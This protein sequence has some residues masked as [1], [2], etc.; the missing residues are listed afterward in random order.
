MKT[1][2]RNGLPKTIID[3]S[4][5]CMEVEWVIGI[6]FNFQMLR[7]YTFQGGKSW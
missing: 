1:P 2:W 6:D 5:T 7:F 3:W 4:N